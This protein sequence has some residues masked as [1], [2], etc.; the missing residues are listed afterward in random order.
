MPKTI[1]NTIYISPEGGGSGEFGMVNQS[2]P[3]WVL[4][5]VRWNV[6]DTLRAPQTGLS[7]TLLGV[8]RPLVVENDCIQV[9]VNSN[10]GVLTP[11]MSATLVET[12]V[13]YSTLV[14]PG[15]FCL[16]NMLNWEIDARNL[17][18]RANASNGGPINGP[19]D[20]FKGIFKVQ[21]VRKTITT[22]P[23]SGIKRVLIRI[24]GYA[25]TEFN[26]MIYYNP[27]QNRDNQ[28]T[29]KDSLLFMTNIHGDYKQLINDN[30]ACQTIIK[31]LIQSF[32]GVGVSDRGQTSTSN[33]AVITANTHFYIPQMVGNFLGVTSAKAA[34][35]VYNYIFGIQLYA[36]TG[37][38]E[39]NPAIVLNP[40][41]L[42]TPNNR[43]YYTTIPCGGEVFLKA[44]YWNQTNA[45]SIINQYTNAPL[46]ELYTCFRLSPP[47]TG[48]PQGKVMPTV[49]FRQIPFTTDFFGKADPFTLQANVTK[50]SSLPRWHISPS[51]V[52]S[53]DIGR[54]EAARIN[55][56]QYYVQ[57]S[58][59]IGKPDAFIAAQTRSRNYVYDINDVQRSGLRPN[60]V[61]TNFEDLTLLKD[62]Y[63]GRRWAYILGDALIGGHLK[64]NGT[65][66]CVGITYP[67]PVG[68]NLEFDD[69]V[70]HIEEVTH[71]CGI[72]P[73]NGTKSFRTTLRLSNGISVSNTNTGLQ[74]AEMQ[75]TNA[76]HDRLNDYN[77]TDIMPG[78]SE[79]Q[80]I[81]SRHGVVEVSG[82]TIN[83]TD[84]PF[85]QPGQI[86]MPLTR[87][88]HQKKSNT[89]N[90]GGNNNGL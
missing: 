73:Q 24:D 51:L 26:N 77:N 10:K 17:A 80:D 3:T 14:A 22:D 47:S 44:E 31:F 88:R 2:S 32:I 37:V 1:A 19:A 53:S 48:Y 74:Y 55:F 85:A 52:Y 39:T 4:T 42:T 13:N 7:S 68:D 5:F 6:R 50:F 83:H 72:D 35:D 29:A 34:K 8:R 43:F 90:S 63:V 27:Y 25:F 84:S 67:I 79:A 33:G 11:S 87:T 28:G 81:I 30:N 21:S 75:F 89:N 58:A 38:A 59:S 60:V 61:S 86:I 78:V 56:V 69:I 82:S 15:D 18:I 71:S 23:E 16:V 70:F 9:T 40:T 57:P 46:N 62:E 66:E 12:D 49:V 20:G 65:I 45:W 76:Y 36:G 64:M 54:D 41:N